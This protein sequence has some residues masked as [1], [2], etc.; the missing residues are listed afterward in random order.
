MKKVILSLLIGIILV[1]GVG[2]AKFYLVDKPRFIEGLG[3]CHKNPLC[4]MSP[5]VEIGFPLAFGV[6]DDTDAQTPIRLIDRR[7]AGDISYNEPFQW[8]YSVNLALDLMLWSGLTYVVLR[9][10]RRIARRQ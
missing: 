6:Y 7:T 5:Y 4:D 2:F 10:G 8:D 3:Q 9:Y 1:F